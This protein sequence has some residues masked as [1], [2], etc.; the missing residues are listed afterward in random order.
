MSTWSEKIQVKMHHKCM[1]SLTHLVLYSW[2]YITNSTQVSL[3][4]KFLNGPACGRIFLI[5]KWSN[6]RNAA[7][8]FWILSAIIQCLIYWQ[9][10]SLR[11]CIH[12]M[13]PNPRVRGHGYKWKSTATTHFKNT[14]QFLLKFPMA[15][16]YISVIAYQKA[17]IFGTWLL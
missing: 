3:E 13:T 9:E 17:F 11:V 16:Q 2:F 15:V 5:Y 7:F 8:I 14:T 6:N 4:C 12:I 10:L 1:K